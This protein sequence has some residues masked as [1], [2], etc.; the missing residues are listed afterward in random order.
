MRIGH[1]AL[2]CSCALVGAFV[3]A[4]SP[5]AAEPVQTT[6]RADANT[7]G[8]WRFQEGQGDRSACEGRAPAAVLRGATWV[9]GRDGFALAMHSGYV[10][11]PDDPSIRP[12]HGFTAEVW[13]K[14]NKSKGDLICKNSVYMIRLGGSMTGLIGVDGHW[15]TLRGRHTVPTSRWTHLAI[16]YDAATKTGALYI[17]GVLDG[18]QQFTGVTKGLLSQGRAELRL[19]LNDWNPLGS[20]VDGKV[21]ALR[22]SK[23]ARTFEPLSTPA[24]TSVASGNLVPNGNFEMGLLGWRLA[25]EGDATLLWGPEEKGAASGRRCLRTL[26]GGEKG[27]D[28]RSQAPQ[29]ALLSRPIPAVPG[30]R[31]TLTARV[32]SDGLPGRQATIAAIAAGGSGGGRRGEGGFRQSAKLTTE[33]QQVT[34]AF[35]LPN[36]WTAASLCVRIDPP[37]DGHIWVDDVRLV[38]GERE[39]PAALREMV[40]VGVKAP[41]AGNLFFAGRDEQA[42][43]SIVNGDAK[44]HRLAVRALIVDWDNQRL[45]P[46]SVGTFDVPAGGV[47]EIAFPIETARRG[48][49]RLDF[50][51]TAEG[52]TWRQGAPLKYAV[53]VPLKGVGDAEN[54]AFGMNTHME[55]EPTAHLQHSMEVLSQCGVKWI[56]AWWGWGMAEKERG[57]FDWTEYD[58]QLGVVEAAGMRAMPILLRY[59]PQ[60]EQ[61]W[62]GAL[63]GIQRPPYKMEQWG[64]FVGKVIERYKGRVTAWELWNEPTMDNA[65]FTPE[66][67][68][69]LLRATAPA[70][71][72]N[73][74][75]AK[76]IGFA[77]VPLHFL[78]RTLA[79]GTAPTMDVVSEH[80]YSQLDLPEI[81]IPKQT[82]AVRAIMK[83]NGGEKPIWH[84]EQ[85]LSGDDDG[86]LPATLSEAEVAALYMRN[87][88][89]CRSLGVEK[90]FWFSAQTSPTYGMTVFYEDYIPRARLVA[91]NACASLLEGVNCRKS[92]RPSNNAY[93]F[94]FGGKQSV[95]VVW[96]MNAPTRLSLPMRPEGIKAFD[97]M[98]NPMTV[99]AAA[100]GIEVQIPAERPTY[101][102]GGG[103][104]VATW[105]KALAAAQVA[106]LV[107]VAVEARQVNGKLAVT[108][109]NQSRTA[110]DG[111]AEIAAAAAA[112]HFHS[113]APGESR[114]LTFAQN[115]EIRVRVGDREMRELKVAAPQR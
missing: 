34:H 88:L 91:L 45:P 73:D 100:D 111:V 108:V 55:R 106:D 112:Q 61:A 52:Q 7:V 54:S 82:A 89:L 57:K 72:D 74:P 103:A 3:I 42:A 1:P 2:L 105:E 43:L 26:A 5:A 107:P 20:E 99:E 69:A 37:R 53:I 63:T 44:P 75:Q 24:K 51:V 77:G 27:S 70:L 40:G 21:A 49:F 68:A 83:A 11:I 56:R 10:T 98:G 23:V 32:R 71:R 81:N 94:L 58:R 46:V 85:G 66:M 64:A 78:Q 30:A 80:S 35:T 31:Y 93:L 60:Y 38:A 76:I 16:T 25:G 113:L 19:G 96:N 22:I 62:A 84:T 86:Y 41:R 14:L 95:C 114:V 79:L 92:Y 65:G 12:E 48:T 87:L 101:L 8:L 15:Q 29:E 36:D 110:Q 17:D 39:S 50:E 67:Y 13:V 33:W 59:Y 97:L 4:G 47:K 115:G 90:Y 18:K 109:T 102:C 104:D 9:P 6:L 28:L